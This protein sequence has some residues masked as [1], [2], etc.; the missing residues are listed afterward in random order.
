[1][2]DM[3]KLLVDRKRELTDTVKHLLENHEIVTAVDL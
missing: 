3:N 2:A 1:M